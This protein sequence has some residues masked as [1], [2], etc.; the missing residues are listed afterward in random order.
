AI[1]DRPASAKYYDSSPDLWNNFL[2]K[3]AAL[4][5]CLAGSVGV[6]GA[7][8]RT[9]AREAQAGRRSGAAPPAAFAPAADAY[10][11]YLL[12]R[13]LESDDDVDGAIA[14]Y[15]RAAAL[16]PEAAEP[17]ADLAALYLRQNRVAEAMSAAEAALKIS[18][19]NPDAHRVLGP[20][21]A[22]LTDADRSSPG[23]AR[24]P[25]ST[26]EAARMAIEHLEQA[27]ESAP[28][29]PDPNVRA[30]LARMY[31][32]TSAFDKAIPILRDLVVRERGW[33]E[34]IGLLAEAYAGAGKNAE[35]IA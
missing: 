17:Q 24:T 25:E 27:V 8:E 5:L 32:R 15:K 29:A 2:M 26:A 31:V 10:N 22:A 23:G 21:Y 4:I 35:A 14:A 28:G 19:S 18:P 7:A 6:A 30:M 34:G 16:D 20:I 1:P 11:Q 13:R 33:Q 12:A 3:L 9:S